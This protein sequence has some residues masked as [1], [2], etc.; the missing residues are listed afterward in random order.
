MKTLPEYWKAI[1][2]AVTGVGSVL[3]VVATTLSDPAITEVT[4]NA[5]VGWAAG[6]GTAI[7]VVGTIVGVLKRNAQRV[8]QIQAGLDAGEITV[9]DL[10]SLVTKN[11]G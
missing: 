3:G 8:D 4:N 11:K 2:I 1:I 5:S 6:V 7:T 10:E 9:A